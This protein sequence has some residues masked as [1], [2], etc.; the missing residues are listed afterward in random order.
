MSISHGRNSIMDDESIMPWGKHQGLKMANVPSSYLRYIFDKG[1][2]G[3]AVKAYI[4]KN[5]DA[6]DKDINEQ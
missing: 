6:I 3:G 1:W 2:C 5:L 4:R